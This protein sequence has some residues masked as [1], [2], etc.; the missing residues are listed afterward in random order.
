MKKEIRYKLTDKNMQTYR[1]FQWELNKEFSAP[2][3]GELCTDGWFHVYTHPLLAVLLS[4]THANFSDSDL[5]L[6]EAEVSGRSKNDHGLKEGWEHVK[7]LRELEV[8]KITITQKV[9]FGILCAKEVYK[10]GSWNQWADN[11][12]S[13]EDRSEETAARAVDYA[14][15]AAARAAASAA[16]A[17]RVAYA[18]ARAAAYAADTAEIDLISLAEKAMGY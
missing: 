5:R 15:Y 13:G 17:A 9:A 2:G 12:L 14:G 10:D 3:T 7:L 4:P 1:G 6:F 8:P 16:Y 18:A 11:W